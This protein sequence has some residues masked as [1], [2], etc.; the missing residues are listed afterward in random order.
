MIIACP[1]AL[2]GRVYTA[3]NLMGF[4]FTALSQWSVGFMLDLFPGEIATGYM[5]AFGVLLGVQGLGGVWYFV[6]TR[7][8]IGKKTLL[9]KEAEAARA[10]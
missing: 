8:G 2:A 10:A 6:A 1:V 4:G 3:I 7:A 5:V 9:E